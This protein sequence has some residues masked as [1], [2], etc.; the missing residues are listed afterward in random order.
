MLLQA[1]HLLSQ[2]LVLLHAACTRAEG[3]E[4][5]T[6]TGPQCGALNQSGDVLSTTLM[7]GV[8]AGALMRLE[9]HPDICRVEPIWHSQAFAHSS[10]FQ[11]SWDSWVH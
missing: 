10:R 1:C 11:F 3:Q 4:G 2:K 9:S 8:A 6:A 5:T 7:I